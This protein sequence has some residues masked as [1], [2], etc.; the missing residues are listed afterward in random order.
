MK[1][2]I[3]RISAKQFWILTLKTF[4]VF[5]ILFSFGTM[6]VLIFAS[7]STVL[8]M[9]VMLMGAYESYAKD[10]YIGIKNKRIFLKQITK[11]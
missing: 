11:S 2:F 9:L 3:K 6:S 7:I 1:R 5:C 4:I 10:P 8:F